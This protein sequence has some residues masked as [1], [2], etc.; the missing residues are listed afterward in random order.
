LEN[1]DAIEPI[2][3]QLRTITFRQVDIEELDAIAQARRRYYT[4]LE[5]ILADYRTL[6]ELNVERNDAGQNVLDEAQS[7]AAAG[8]GNSQDLSS[9]AVNR[10]NTSVIT[11]AVGLALAVVIAII[12]AVFLT[13]SIVKALTKGVRFAEEIA[14]GDLQVNLDINQRDEIGTLADALKNMQKALQYK[15][16]VIERIAQKDLTVD[17]EKSSEKDGLGAS[18]IEMKESLTDILKQVNFAVDQVASGSDQVSQAS[19]NLSQGATEQASSLE[20]ISSSLSEVNGQSQQ[21]ANNATEATGLA[22]K[23]AEDAVGGNGQM[24][25]L[26]EAM[27]KIDES[28]DEIKKVVKVIDDIAFQINLLA[29]NANV[30]AARAGKY[31]KGF[32]VVAEEVRNLAV[33]SAEAVQET[34]GMVEVSISNIETGN[35]LVGKTAEQLEEIV[36]GANK[37]AEFLEEIATA[38]REQ[39]EA[40]E[41]VNSGLDQ[42]DQVTQSNTASAEES[43]SAAEELAGQS[44]QLKSMI[45]TFRLE[46][47]S[48]GT[49]ALEYKPAQAQERRNFGGGQ[50]SR[51]QS[52]Q[53]QSGSGQSYGG[54]QQG[55]QQQYQQPRQAQQQGQ[56]PGGQTQQPRQSRQDQSRQRGDETG[57]KPLDPSEVIQLDDDDFEN[58]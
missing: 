52:G 55:G 45:A 5:E 51:Q 20:E 23:A 22:K 9:A 8:I 33:R 30:E 2:A 11:I 21:N 26:T 1:L 34:T 36:S 13:I 43:A 38:S 41:Q 49:Y 14:L 37:V 15:A 44:Q 28:S 31:G 53:Q 24:K 27:R 12:L 6:D 58:F 50:Q 40:I 18:L 17:V 39:A 4:A 3:A 54:G 25:E 48:R 47:D 56:R 42:I 19:Q 29:L 16:E 57:I 46:A 35:D 10:V 7:V 32:A